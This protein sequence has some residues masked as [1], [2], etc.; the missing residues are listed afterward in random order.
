MVEALKQHEWLRDIIL[1]R[2]GERLTA[3]ELTDRLLNKPLQDFLLDFR[4]ACREVEETP[5]DCDAPQSVISRLALFACP[6]L[7][8]PPDQD[9]LL[10]EIA[11]RTNAEVSM[12]S[13]DRRDPKF[14]LTDREPVGEYAIP[15]SPPAGF[16]KIRGEFSDQLDKHIFK[17][18]ALYTIE[19]SEHQESI[20]IINS[21]LLEQRSLR[22]SLYYT[23]DQRILKDPDLV[24]N[25][26]D[27][28]SDR[29]KGL[30]VIQL[31]EDSEHRVVQAAIARHIAFFLS[32]ASGS[33]R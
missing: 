30:R 7:V 28:L 21:F 13:F 32:H 24:R 27:F 10:A 8:V 11:T 29:Y 3:E 15:A 12:A 1:L 31:S 19:E 25:T 2:E 4:H 18:A 9:G 5:P 14:V 26:V 33:A 17:K 22:S 6:V 20:E 23:I 16:E